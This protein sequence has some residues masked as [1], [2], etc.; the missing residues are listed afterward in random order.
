MFMDILG[1]FAGLLTLGVGISLASGVAF[2]GL[3]ISDAIGGGIFGFMFWMGYAFAVVIPAFA[4][5]FVLAVSVGA[6]V[7]AQ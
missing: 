4:G 2:L 3:K 5:A 7:S 6:W 1:V